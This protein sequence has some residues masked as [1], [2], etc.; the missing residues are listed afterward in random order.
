[1]CP[2]MVSKWAL[3]VHS[4]GVK[5][6]SWGSERCWVDRGHPDPSLVDLEEVGDQGVEINIRI[7]EIV[8][9]QFLPVPKQ[10]AVSTR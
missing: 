9:R 4:W 10:L 6:G 3:A 1:M 8:E 2:A 7:G 5:A